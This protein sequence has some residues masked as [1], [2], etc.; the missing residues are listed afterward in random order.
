MA[1]RELPFA[2]P[3]RPPKWLAG[4]APFLEQRSTVASSAV[5]DMGR[6]IA[7]YTTEEEWQ[8]FHEAGKKR[9]TKEKT[10]KKSKESAVN[11]E[12][13]EKKPRKRGPPSAVRKR[14]N[15]IESIGH[16]INSPEL[17]QLVE[18]IRARWE[19]E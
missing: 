9:K 6:T 11:S 8:H 10:E 14:L 1:S 18:E 3:K 4:F 5:T 7:R 15:T 19:T 17:V 2:V 16:E 12:A 13:S